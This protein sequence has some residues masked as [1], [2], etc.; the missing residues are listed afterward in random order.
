MKEVILNSDNFNDELNNTDKLVL[1][2]F[3]ATWCGPCQMLAPV[4]SEIAEE[5]S[6]IV[7]ICKIDV[8][9][10]REL[11]IKYDIESIPTLVFFKNGSKIKSMVGFYSKAELVDIIKM[12]K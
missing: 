12:L 2:D 8:D 7:K 3:F 6:D 1:V 9:Q 5:Y 10:N 11:A 4:I